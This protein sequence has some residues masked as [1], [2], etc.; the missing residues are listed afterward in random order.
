MTSNTNNDESQKEGSDIDSIVLV[1]NRYPP[2]TSLYRYSEDIMKAFRVHAIQVNLL[3]SQD[4]WEREHA[5]KDFKPGIRFSNLLNHF[6][7]NISF[8]DAARFMKE[9]KKQHRQIIV[10]YANQ[11][12]GVFRGIGEIR[13]VSVH[14]SPYDPTIVSHRQRYYTHWLYKRLST[15]ERI[16][17]QTNTLADELKNFGFNGRIDVIPLA[18]S[19][20][21]RPLN[22]DKKVLREK[23][24]LPLNRKIVLSVSSNET[25]KNLSGVKKAMI[26]LGESFSLVRVGVSVGNSITFKNVGDKKLN[27]LYNAC[28][29]LLFPSLYEGF[30]LPIV[31]AFAS[32]LPVVTSRIPTIEEVSGSAAVLVDPMNNG[33]IVEGVREAIED[34]DSLVRSGLKRAEYFTFEKFN[35]RLTEYYRNLDVCR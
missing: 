23:L 5:G 30:G 13:I 10:H 8:R 26:S 31:E 3:F 6:I 25:R 28:D 18:Y 24:G 11:F 20:I 34:S 22:V 21:F 1:V 33:E 16:I 29:V 35:L 12:S 2:M 19:P 17:T 14:D 27:E 9:L 7:M 15:E 4:G 32:G